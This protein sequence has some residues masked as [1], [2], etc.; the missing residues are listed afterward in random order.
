MIKF[1]ALV[2]VAIAVALA[3]IHRQAFGAFLVFLPI[4]V[5]SVVAGVTRNLSLLTFGLVSDE[6][7]ERWYSLGG[8]FPVGFI[9]LQCVVAGVALIIL[10][11]LSPFIK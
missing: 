2:G 5:L 9:Y 1:L 3:L 10:V 7:M 11:L 6:T 4:G 8:L